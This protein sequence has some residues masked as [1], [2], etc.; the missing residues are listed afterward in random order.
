MLRTTTLAG[1]AALICGAAAQAHVV[2]SRTD[3]RPGGY[4]A[5]A[6]R[7]S[8]GCDGSPTTA[9]TVTIPEGVA[10]AKPQP[11]PGWSVRIERAPLASPVPGEGGRMLT[12]RVAAITWSGRLPEDEFDEFGLMLKLPDRAGPLYFPVVQ[13]CG[14]GQVRWTDIPTP[15]QAWHDVPHPAPVLR[16]DPAGRSSAMDHH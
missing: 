1:I 7:V 15:G 11:K 3:A 4:Y 10:V 8:H 14:Q 16:L 9:V 13:T 6:L 12:E 2:F 5:G